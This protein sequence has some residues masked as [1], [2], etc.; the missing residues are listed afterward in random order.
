LQSQAQIDLEIANDVGEYIYDALGFVLF[1]L[2]WDTDSELQVCELPEPWA[3]KYGIKYG[4]DRWACELLDEVSAAAAKNAFDGKHAVDPILAAVSSGH[5]IGKSF[6]TSMLI[7][8]L[9]STRP[10]SK[11]TVTANTS[12]QLRTKT[13]GELGK[14]VKKC[15]T[16]HWFEYNNGKGNMN[17]YHKIHK[18]SWR[19][20][21]Q[22]CREE[23]SEAFAGQHRVTST[24]Y[25]IFDEASAVPSKIWEVAKGGLTD[26]EPMMFAFGNP[27]RNTGEFREA[28]R[29]DRLNWITKQVDSREVQITNKKLLN[30]WA[31]HYG[32]DSDFVRVRIRG[33]FPRASAKQFIGEDLV[34]AAF[35]RGLPEHNWNFAPVII[36]CDPAWSG[37]D[38]LVILRRQGL[39]VW[40]ER[41]IPK[42]DNDFL[43]AEIIAQLEDRHQAD[44]VF[45]DLGYGTGIASAGTTMGR[46][47]HLISFAEK[48][49][50][51]GY[52]NKR[53][54][55]WGLMKDWLA[56]GGCIP[57]EEDLRQDLI[58]PETVPRAD[59]KIQ[60]EPKEAM[61]KRGLPSPNIGDALALSFARPVVKKVAMTSNS[62]YDKQARDYDPLDGY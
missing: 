24:S 52:I 12:D 28:F 46:Q 43:I 35:G 25:Y 45:I 23:N 58:G 53:A 55:M 32:D 18:D 34:S 26:G 56:A 49:I 39:M 22:T 44:A 27:T 13:W 50:D 54:E 1:T 62:I 16:G 30:E 11:G 41:R 57:A 5:G 29:R 19:C 15:L 37:D 48:A 14:W 59:G 60:L 61:K 47:W 51:P 9:I 33:I 6:L 7:L 42:N 38:E 8:W 40:I 2:P 3:S 21:A 17:I 10:M 31:E 4:P 36:T 20:D